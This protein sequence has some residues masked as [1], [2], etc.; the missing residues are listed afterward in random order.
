M[1]LDGKKWHY[2]AVK[3]LSALLRGTLSTNKRD[4]YCLNCPHSFRR[5]KKLIKWES[6]L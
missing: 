5:E 4:L 6:M 1:I 3:R 2:L